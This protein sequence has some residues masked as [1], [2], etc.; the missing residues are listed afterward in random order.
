MPGAVYA[1]TRPLPAKPSQSD[2]EL[3]PLL[4]DE[5]HFG[6]AIALSDDGRLL[7][8]ASLVSVSEDESRGVIRIYQR[9]LSDAKWIR[10]QTIIPS[11]PSTDPHSGHALG[12]HTNNL[13][14]GDIC[15]DQTGY[16]SGAVFGYQKLQDDT[17]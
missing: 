5:H 3:Q 8:I 15:A 14:V 13:L 7:A 6:R 1:F 17:H 2:Q 4:D 11:H 12:F 16:H 10:H 9:S